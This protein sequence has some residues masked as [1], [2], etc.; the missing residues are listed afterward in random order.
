M[1]KMTM[2]MNNEIPETQR[3]HVYEEHVAEV[4]KSAALVFGQLSLISE[5]KNDL[6]VDYVTDSHM[7]ETTTLLLGQLLVNNK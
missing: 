4:I 7:E 6:Y 3:L 5:Q 2:V 1:T